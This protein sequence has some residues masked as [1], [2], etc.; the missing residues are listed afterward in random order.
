MNLVF[1]HL[2]MVVYSQAET[3]RELR[4]F[5]YDQ[6]SPVYED[7]RQ[8]IR[9]VFL[10]AAAT[11]PRLELVE[12]TAD[13]SVVSALLGRVGVSPYHTGYLTG[14]F[15]TSVAEL[16]ASGFK[17]LGDPAPSPAFDGRRF[18]FLYHKHLGLTEL[19]ASGEI[20]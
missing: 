13:D 4:R 20:A 7:P 1:H 12:P 18:C 9:I 17:R 16:E 6:T 10:T 5:G 3:A 11:A 19:I 15:D 8:R 14:T 2:G